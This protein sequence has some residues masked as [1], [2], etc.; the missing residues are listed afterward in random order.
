MKTIQTVQDEAGESSF[1]GIEWVSGCGSMLR[2]TH[3]REHFDLGS[4][5]FTQSLG[6][7]HPAVV[8]AV[9]AQAREL[10]NVHDGRQAVR[11]RAATALAALLPRQLRPSAFLNTGSEAVEAALRIARRATSRVG[12]VTRVAGLRRGFHGKTR[13]SREIVSWDTPGEAAAPSLLGYSPY[14]Y[15]CPFKATYPGCN[16]LCAELTVKQIIKRHDV[17]VLVAEPVLGAGG[18]IV[19]PSGYWE[20]ITAGCRAHDVVLVADEVLTGGGRTGQFLASE[21]LGMGADIVTL[22]KGLASG[23]PISAIAVT[24]NLADSALW[25]SAGGASSSYSGSGVP[26]AAA[27]ATME[28]LYAGRIEMSR[29][30]HSVFIDALETMAEISIIGDVRHLGLFGAL[31]FVRPGSDVPA[32]ELAR[33][34]VKQAARRQVRI[35]PGDHVV[36][37]APPLTS[38]SSALRVA[39][40]AVD[41]AVREVAAEVAS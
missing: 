12:G 7:C 6:H 11:R 26:L 8:N 3:G 39:M 13:G 15:R 22:A 19:P 24:G 27:A 20:T 10:E 37:L 23:Y 1:T 32:P 35:I 25:E 40:N 34:V 28:E 9:V 33:A 38:T 16:L 30:L 36:R 17:G 21:Q 29:D 18:C 4:G 14:C 41:Q 2:D 31:E 5:I